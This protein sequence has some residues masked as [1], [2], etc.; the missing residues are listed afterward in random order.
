MRLR[1][2][3][4]NVLLSAVL[5]GAAPSSAY[6][7]APPKRAV[8]SYDGRDGGPTTT[9]DVLLWFPRILVSP[10]Y[11]VSE[12][13]IRRPLGAI[14]TG[15]ERAKIPEALYDFFAFGPDHKA[16][17]AP[18]ALIDF[19]FRPSVG[20]YGFWKDAGF[21]GHSMSIHAATWGL[22]WLAAGFTDRISFKDESSVAVMATGIRR[23]DHAFYGLGP[24]TLESDLSRYSSDQLELAAQGDVHIW[25]QTRLTTTM[26]F[27]SVSFAPGSYGEDPTV[28]EQVGR[29]VF[30]TPPGF[31]RGYSIE[32][33]QMMFAFDN[34]LPRPA[35]GDGVRF[36]V[37]GFQGNDVRQSPGS[38]FVRYGATLGGFWDVNGHNRVLSLSGGVQFADPLTKGG[39]IPFT[40][41]VNYGGYDYLRGFFPGRLIDRSGINATLRYRWPIWS[42]LDGTMELAT[43]NVFGSHLNDLDP[44]LLRLS[45]AIGIESVGDPDNSL[46][47]LLGAG[48]ETFMHG[49]QIDSVR[50][51]FGTNRGF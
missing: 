8:P 31:D 27:R 35:H 48:T 15:A 39:T 9:E 40:E 13:I 30:R 28:E 21:E 50:V 32:Y 22:D 20:I 7:K 29:N 2:L 43:G 18:Y 41:L 17:I 14:V 51:L 4:R 34:R 19:G 45:G 38:S 49:A 6:A 16:G 37:D 33:N 10:L 44:R 36:E 46:M 23:P 42:Y 3:A 1:E 12:Y 11:F 26:G 5:V 47:I 25:R 24:R